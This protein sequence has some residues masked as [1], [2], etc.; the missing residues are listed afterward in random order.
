[1]LK[2]PLMIF[3]WVVLCLSLVTNYYLFQKAIVYYKALNALRL[4]PLESEKGSGGQDID[5]RVGKRPLIVFFGDSRIARWRPDP[6]VAGC[7]FINKGLSGQT[8]AQLKLRLEKDVLSC[9]PDIVVL[10]AGVND[11]K[12][13]GLFPENSKRILS[14]CKANLYEMIQTLKAEGIAVVVMTIFPTGEPGFVRSLIWPQ[15]IDAAIQETNRFLLKITDKRI[16]VIDADPI[17]GK[18]RF[19]HPE[20]E[21]DMLHLTDRA[22]AR[23]NE[24]LRPH[25]VE[26]LNNLR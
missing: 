24:I 13:I 3:P 12:T 4:D 8:T 17:L 15:E 26:L 7:T 21:K 23:L 6:D 22:Y 18:D 20:F 10:Q 5:S 14:E 19:I 16:S 1:M 9:S 11:L 2:R 25:L